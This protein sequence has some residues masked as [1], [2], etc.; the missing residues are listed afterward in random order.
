VH[1]RLMS[2]EAQTTAGKGYSL[3]CVVC[4]ECFQGHGCRCSV[5]LV[6]AGSTHLVQAAWTVATGGET[7]TCSVLLVHESEALTAIRSSDSGSSKPC[8]RSTA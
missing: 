8:N 2:Q 5:D 7:A 3:E 1:K 4:R 6:G